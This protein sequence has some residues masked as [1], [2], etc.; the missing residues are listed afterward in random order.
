MVLL[1]RSDPGQ[2]VP[3]RWITLP[4]PRS[5]NLQALLQRYPRRDDP[6]LR[7]LKTV[8]DSRIAMRDPREPALAL[9][10]T[11]RRFFPIPPARR[12]TSPRLHGIARAS[13]ILRQASFVRRP[14]C[15]GI[16]A[17]PHIASGPAG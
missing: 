16:Q 10:C 1:P 13:L 12:D 14:L 2:Q 15:P 3:A 6:S 9:H 11:D 8:S 5:L 4:W 17:Q 7:L